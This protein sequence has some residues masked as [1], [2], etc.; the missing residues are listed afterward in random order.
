MTVP[1][2]YVEENLLLRRIV[3]ETEVKFSININ[4]YAIVDRITR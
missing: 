2:P 3:Q 1:A 4:E